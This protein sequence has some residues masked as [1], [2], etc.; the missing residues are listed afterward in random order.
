MPGSVVCV[1]GFKNNGPIVFSQERREARLTRTYDSPPSGSP[2]PSPILPPT[3][4]AAQNIVSGSVALAG[5]FPLWLRVV[6]QIWQVPCHI[7]IDQSHGKPLQERMSRE[8]TGSDPAPFPV[9]RAPEAGTQGPGG[10][11]GIVNSLARARGSHI[12]TL[13][14]RLLKKKH[15]IFGCDL[16]SKFSFY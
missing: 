8:L 15:E 12:H 13:W 4:V 6:C 16:N 1:W 10:R 5:A 9:T 2:P 14:A 7:L 11:G 3:S